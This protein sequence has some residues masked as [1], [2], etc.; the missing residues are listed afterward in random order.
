MAN[1]TAK[2]S[3]AVALTVVSIAIF[4]GFIQ[5]LLGTIALTPLVN[6]DYHREL[7]IT[8][9]AFAQSLTFL[10]A[11]VSKAVLALSLKYAHAG[12]QILAGLTLCATTFVSLKL[13]Q[14]ANYSLIFANLIFLVL[15]VYVGNTIERIAPT[16]VFTTLLTSRLILV[17]QGSKR[18]VPIKSKSGKKRA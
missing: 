17:E 8:Y 9:N 2:T 18:V 6:A 12:I 13:V 14:L 3:R 11:Y 7:K 5:A 10:H 4:L 1:P 15:Q 16:L